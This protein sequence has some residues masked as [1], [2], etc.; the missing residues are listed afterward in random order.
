[1]LK[2]ALTFHYRVTLALTHLPILTRLFPFTN[3][4]ALCINANS[5]HDP[6]WHRATHTLMPSH[7]LL[8]TERV[9]Y[10]ATITIDITTVY[11][12]PIMRTDDIVWP[13]N[14]TQYY[15]IAR[16]CHHHNHSHPQVTRDSSLNQLVLGSTHMSAITFSCVLMEALPDTVVFG[17]TVAGTTMCSEYNWTPM[18]SIHAP[19]PHAICHDM[20]FI[21]W[22]QHA[23][24]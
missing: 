1:M 4:L 12:H 19:N 6:C 20:S 16:P 8:N 18:L 7:P 15:M 2:P 22:N 13:C 10:I 11:C 21:S 3:T 17:E 24:L 9:A 5:E 23:I 14:H